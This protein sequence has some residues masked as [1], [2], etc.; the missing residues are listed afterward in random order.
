MILGGLAVWLFFWPLVLCYYALS[1]SP[2]FEA[3]VQMKIGFVFGFFVFV[4]AVI[5]GK[6]LVV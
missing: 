3:S 6:N 5:T 1:L 4:G 2:L